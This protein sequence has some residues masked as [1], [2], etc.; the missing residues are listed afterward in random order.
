[1]AILGIKVFNLFLNNKIFKI[2]YINFNYTLYIVGK[3]MD[4]KNLFTDLRLSTVY[5]TF[6]YLTHSAIDYLY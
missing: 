1:M 6:Q 3:N 5:L 2:G 4:K